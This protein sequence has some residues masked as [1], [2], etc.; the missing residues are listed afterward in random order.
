MRHI[1]ALLA[2]AGFAVAADPPAVTVDWSRTIARSQTELT[3]Q[4]CPEP[5]LRRGYPIHDQLWKALRDMKSNVAR[6]QFWHPY[7]RL[8]VAELE[9]PHDGVTSWD[10]SLIDPIVLDFVAA[11]EGRPVMLNLS[12]LPQWMYRTPESV[13]YPKDPDEIT[14]KYTQSTELRD[15]SLKEIVDYYHR[16]ASWYVKGGFTDEAGK[17]HESGH[18]L[19][20][21]WWEVL[22]EVEQEHDISPAQYNAIYDAVVEDLHKL[23]PEMKFS[24][25]A[26]ATPATGAEYIHT[27]LNPKDHKPGMPLDMFSYHFYAAGDVDES[28]E[29]QQRTFFHKADQFMAT[30]HYVESIHRR[31]SPQ[32][33]TFINELGSFSPETLGTNQP[34]P[35]SYWTLSGSMFAYLYPQ[36]VREG[37]DL[38]GAAE[39]IDYP[40]QFAGA[41]LVDWVTGQPNARY[42]VLKL[43]RD[44]FGPGD[45][46]VQTGLPSP[47]VA[48]QAFVTPKGERKLLIVNKRDHEVTL[49]LPVATSAQSQ[50][51][52]VDPTTGSQPPGSTV[53]T[54]NSITLRSQAVAVITLKP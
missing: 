27:F 46:L 43:L 7:P 40:G 34:I 38:I 12:T 54:G 53:L 31:L 22:N 3:I 37:I 45:T 25:L 35:A 5:P 23:D 10:F 26:L 19:K 14:W 36:L 18:H 30:V 15:P 13:P 42:R 21:A 6:I 44:N 48:A 47:F 11:S 20:I 39:L 17:W 33:K 1:L 49:T 4:V 32:T 8:G 16:V 29:M 50:M 24:G 52:Y 41:T 2:L 9:P 28:A 51:D